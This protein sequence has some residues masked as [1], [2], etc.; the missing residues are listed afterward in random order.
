[1][2]S[3][4]EAEKTEKQ[5]LAQ[6][7]E[8][9]EADFVLAQTI[10]NSREKKQSKTMSVWQKKAEQIREKLGIHLL[11]KQ[12]TVCRNAESIEAAEQGDRRNSKKCR[13]WQKR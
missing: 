13:S 10:A 11:P 7:V 5:K 8:K 12:K 2:A 3:L 1:M 6:A 4:F 9:E